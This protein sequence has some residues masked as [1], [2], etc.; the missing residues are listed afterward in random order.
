MTELELVVPEKYILSVLGV[1]TDNGVFH[2]T[3]T[4][5]LSS[6]LGLESA[7]DWRNRSATYAAMEHRL[8]T[9]MRV[10]HV[11]EGEPLEDI[12]PKLSDIDELTRKTE[13]L[14][15][16][17]QSIVNEL[18]KDEK[19]FEQLNQEI[20]QLQPIAEVG[21]DLGLLQNQRYMLTMIGTI[22]VDNVERLRSSLIR[23][24]FVLET[25]KT[26]G[27]KAVVLLASS[28]NNEDIISRAARSAYLNQLNLPESYKGTPRE[29]LN[30]L[31]SNVSNLQ[32]KIDD[33]KLNLNALKLQRQDEYKKILW[34]IRGNRLLTDAISRFGKYLYTY[35]IVGWVPSEQFPD[36]YKKLGDI[37]KEIIIESHVPDRGNTKQNIPV[38]LNNKGIFGAFQSLVTTY[39]K[40]RYEEIDPTILLTI[41]FPLL[42]GMMFGDIGH[43]F[44]LLILGLVIAS[45][46]VKALQSMSALGTVVAVC[47][48]VAIVFGFLYGSVFGLE[49]LLHPIW[50]QP[51]ENI[52]GILMI[53]V[54]VGVVIL[55]LAFII[56][57]INAWKIK[58]W[59]HFLL[60]GTG[61]AGL[62]FY[63][64][65]IGLA[66]SLLV[67]SLSIPVT[68]FIVLGILSA[69]LIM[70]SDILEKVIHH[71]RPKIEGGFVM[72]FIQ[73]F[74]E[75]FE[76]M[77]S[78]FS[79]SL[80]FVRVGAFA[81][82]HAGLSQVV[83]ILAEM[84]GTPQNIG[85]W[86]AIILGNLFI[87]GFEGMIVG[88]QTLRL[89][90]YEFLSKFFTGGGK[91]FSPLSLHQIRE[92]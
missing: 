24:P 83:F 9:T 10:L 46:K 18:T 59:G 22:P 58:D 77:L 71:E 25:L 55:N 42:F 39:G 70:L 75:L 54:V 60:G 34:Q 36:I 85:Y 69:A 50:M 30:Q 4:S 26:Y 64:S 40:P 31:R 90:Y 33:S 28:K 1:L 91:Q 17:A 67:P 89:E 62:F 48:A 80:S 47:G 51:M 23:V 6:D 76:T 11:D 32:Q 15:F 68:P 29:V 35:L 73:V 12:K 5:S 41:T 63:W 86:V 92:Y 79:N 37:S 66:V 87:I 19:E 27:E 57:L 14:E 88:I 53:T 84:S 49:H 20:E 8:L 61:L 43:G 56:H 72:Y 7:S 44:I 3:D 21:V 16:E 78:L 74:F 2:Q 13:K 81:V 82:A 38:S 45:K 65:M 52:M